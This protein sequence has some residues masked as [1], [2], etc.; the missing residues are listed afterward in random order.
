MVNIGVVVTSQLRFQMKKHQKHLAPLAI[1]LILSTR[2][3]KKPSCET[4]YLQLQNG[5][6]DTGWMTPLHIEPGLSNFW[7][8]WESLTLFEQFELFKNYSEQNRDS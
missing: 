7:N 1:E 3:V 4:K 5:R 2:S 8:L 6:V